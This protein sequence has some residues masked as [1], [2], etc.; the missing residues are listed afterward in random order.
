MFMDSLCIVINKFYEK[1]RY[2]DYVIIKKMLKLDVS[3]NGSEDYKK[4]K[5]N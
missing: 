2:L 4:K 5:N 3:Q 1:K